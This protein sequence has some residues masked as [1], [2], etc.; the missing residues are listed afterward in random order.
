MSKN[1]SPKF[2]IITVVKNC[3]KKI[4]TTLQSVFLQ[5]FDN[6]EHIVIDGFSEDK[7]ASIIKNFQNKKII[8][9]EYNDKNLYDAI[10]FALKKKTGSYVLFLHSGDFFFSDDTLKK[11]NNSLDRKSDILIGDCLFFNQS[12]KKIIRSW[13]VKSNK[14]TKFNSY[15]VPHTC[16][17]I[18]KSLVDKVGQYNINY[19]IA[20]DAD[21]LIRLFSLKNIKIKILNDF[22]CFM[23]NGGLSTNYKNFYFKAKEDMN[24][25]MKHFGFFSVFLYILKL[26][27]KLKHFIYKKSYKN[28]K[29]DFY[30]VL[31]SLK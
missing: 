2:S 10:N 29:N 1:Y 17:V 26:S 28:Y 22:I 15:K 14:I 19:K 4:F 7:T 27:S 30:K 25:Y 16:T 18:H 20:S 3:E 6:Y 8:F 5:T 13:K 31:K 11:I 12:N 23:E 21:Y 24:I 9:Y